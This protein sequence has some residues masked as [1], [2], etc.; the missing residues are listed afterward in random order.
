MATGFNQ[1][2]KKLDVTS[3]CN[4]NDVNQATA[5]VAGELASC[6]SD[7]TY[8]LKSCPNG[9]SCYALPKSSGA[10]GVN[11]ECA[12]PSDAA[13]QLSGESDAGNDV[14]A[15]SKVTS[16]PQTTEQPVGGNVQSPSKLPETESVQVPVQKLSSSQAATTPPSLTGATTATSSAATLQSISKLPETESV[17]IPVQRLSSSSP[18]LTTPLSQAQ[19]HSQ[20]SDAATS[21]IAEAKSI[22]P[23]TQVLQSSSQAIASAISQQKSPTAIAETQAPVSTQASSS[24]QAVPTLQSFPPVQATQQ[25]QQAAPISSSSGPSSTPVQ[26]QTVNP[27]Q[28]GAESR[29]ASAASSASIADGGPLFQLPTTTQQPAEPPAQVT[30]QSELGQAMSKAAQSPSVLAQE[31]PAQSTE[32]SLAPAPHAPQAPGAPQATKNS[33]ANTPTSSNDGGGVQIVPEGLASPPSPTA[34][35]NTNAPA[36]TN[37]KLAVQNAVQSPSQSGTP[38]YITVTVTSTTTAH[39]LAPTA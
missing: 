33:G 28:S 20:V 26:T 14:A 4:P 27:V 39:D 38:I 31:Q 30:A 7:G 2:Y 21:P 13:A 15:A 17:Q 9:Q 29:T 24:K 10:T 32:T 6:Q 37:E 8:V 18:T 11:V 23:S 1:V 35:P 3:Q 22:Q 16:I 19:T 5:C 34:A 36:G 25:S 12:V